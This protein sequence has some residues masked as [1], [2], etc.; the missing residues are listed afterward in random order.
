MEVLLGAVGE[1][2]GGESG[3]YYIGAMGGLQRRQIQQ[4]LISLPAIYS[5]TELPDIQVST[6]NL[7]SSFCVSLHY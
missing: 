6:C 3:G 7:G 5:P 4:V 2:E 1:E